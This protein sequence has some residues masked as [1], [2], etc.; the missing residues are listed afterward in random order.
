MISEDWSSLNLVYFIFSIYVH[1]YLDKVMIMIDSALVCT[2]P[3][4]VFLRILFAHLDWVHE[5]HVP[6]RTKT[7][8][9]SPAELIGLSGTDSGICPGLYCVHIARCLYTPLPHG[10]SQTLVLCRTQYCT[11]VEMSVS[12]LCAVS[13]PV[14]ACFIS[15]QL[16]Q[17]SSPI[18]SFKIDFSYNYVILRPCKIF[19]FQLSFP[20]LFDQT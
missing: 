5:A 10:Q 18:R 8:P 19:Y 7:P 1:W 17:C 2:T 9:P 14:K 16:F 12:F 3:C 4:D 6:A 20:L 11:C 15:V 13:C